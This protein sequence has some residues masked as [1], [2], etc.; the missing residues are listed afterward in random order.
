MVCLY[1][2]FCSQQ[3]Q[4]YVNIIEDYV[5]KSDIV[6]YWSDVYI[7]RYNFVSLKHETMSSK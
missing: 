3:F 6:W 7:F 1:L 2:N 5:E 4:Q